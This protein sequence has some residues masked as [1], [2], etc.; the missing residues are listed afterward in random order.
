MFWPI[1][2]SGPKLEKTPFFSVRVISLFP[3]LSCLFSVP[4]Y[5]RYSRK[6]SLKE[7]GFPSPSKTPGSK[8]GKNPKTEDGVKD[9]QSKVSKS[10]SFTDRNRQKQSLKT[11][12]G[13]TRQ[14]SEGQ[15]MLICAMTHFIDTVEQAT[16][17]IL[18]THTCAFVQY[19][20]QLFFWCWMHFNSQCDTPAVGEWLDA[21]LF[22]WM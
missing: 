4:H 13:A 5:V 6:T 9:G 12:E 20:L 11:K 8:D 1:T 18:F 22:C 2:T 14:N 10:W 17:Y 16:L 21:T 15:R 3:L 19:A 7:K